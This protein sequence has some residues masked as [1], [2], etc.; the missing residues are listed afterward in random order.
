MWVYSLTEKVSK[1][2]KQDEFSTYEQQGW[3]KG[4]KMMF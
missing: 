3:L 4:R 1:K 2:I